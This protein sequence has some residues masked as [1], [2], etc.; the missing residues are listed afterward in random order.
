MKKTD[1]IS[2]NFL[3]FLTNIVNDPIFY[4]DLIFAIEF[5]IE[6]AQM[7]FI[8]P[9]ILSEKLFSLKK[10]MK[11]SNFLCVN[12]FKHQAKKQEKT[13]NISFYLQFCG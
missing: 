7:I 13:V 5:I 4:I 6:I 11:I 1:K 12:F 10:Q 9:F 2:C 3:E 8:F